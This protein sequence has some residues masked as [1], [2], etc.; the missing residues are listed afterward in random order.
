[1]PSELHA[2]KWS[3]TRLL[4]AMAIST[5]SSRLSRGVSKALSA[6]FGRCCGCVCCRCCS[7]CN[8]HRCP[9]S[10]RSCRHED[11]SENTDDDGNCGRSDENEEVWAQQWG[12]RAPRRISG[13]MLIPTK[14]DQRAEPLPNL[15]NVAS[16][17]SVEEVSSLRSSSTQPSAEADRMESKTSKSLPDLGQLESAA[18][19]PMMT[20]STFIQAEAVPD[21]ASCEFLRT[22]PVFSK[23]LTGLSIAQLQKILCREPFI[24]EACLRQDIKAYDMKPSRWQEGVT[25]P[26]T[27][28]R[29]M[30]YK[31]PVPD[32]VPSAAR[33]VLTIPEFCTCQTFVRLRARPEE[34][35]MTFQTLS[36]GLPFGENLRLQVTN[37]FTPYTDDTGAGVIFRR[38]IVVAWVKE[39]PWA[40][41]FLKSVVVSQIM[42]AGR[43]SA[44]LLSNLIEEEQRNMLES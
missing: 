8:C 41:R 2:Q 43:D 44:D 4:P 21:A 37:S 32:D 16:R 5:V 22:E 18:L 13:T 42:Q 6:S 9:K 40:L 36:Q 39:L 30:K 15:L 3:L 34:L 23:K 11:E 10:R 20:K 31:M 25:V 24:M 12:I 7:C 1:V 27:Q 38:W 28:I 35:D 33:S 29:A 17:M 19:P 14:A 26:G